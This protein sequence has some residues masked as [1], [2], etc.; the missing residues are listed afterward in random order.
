M[1]HRCDISA[2]R[3]VAPSVFCVC[4]CPRFRFGH[5]GFG[6][7][8]TVAGKT[9]SIAHDYQRR[10]RPIMIDKTRT[11]NLRYLVAVSRLAC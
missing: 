2:A 1:C 10:K 9:I 5:A 3:I 4:I 7:F 6:K 8:L 11:I